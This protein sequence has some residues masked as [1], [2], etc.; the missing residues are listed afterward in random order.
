M[1]FN[2]ID[3][4]LHHILTLS[5][6]YF[7]DYYIDLTTNYYSAKLVYNTEISSLFLSLYNILLYKN[8]K[9][10]ETKTFVLSTIQGIFIFSFIKCRIVD[11]YNNVITNPYF[12]DSL[13]T[14]ERITYYFPRVSI[15]ALFGLN[16]YWFIII[17]KII[18]KHI[19]KSITIHDTENILQYSYGFCFLATCGTYYLFAD[20]FQKWYY[21][22][23]IA[24]DVSCNFLLFLTSYKFHQHI[25]KQLQRDNLLM[26]R[27]TFDY[28]KYLLLDITAIQ[29]RAI[30][31]VYT[32]FNMHHIYDYYKYIF[33]FLVYYLLLVICLVDSVYYNMIVNNVILP[34]TQENKITQKLDLIFGSNAFICIMF[35][36]Y[37][38]YNTNHAI[39]TLILLYVIFLITII[40]PFYNANHLSIH[41]CMIL[42]NYQLV[43]NN[44]YKIE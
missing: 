25:Y 40:K 24:I 32:H 6:V 41:I 44:I 1:P 20:D 34:I 30:A 27:A 8:W 15:Y 21:A 28:K 37:G 16:I 10:P 3:M 19:G 14:N 2:K 31:Q 17:V 33:S 12:F 9:Y 23:Y 7:S 11:Y 38:V 22:D 35:S 4:F 42:M 5:F 29:L 13:L 26:N 18:F 43:I 39:N 36:T